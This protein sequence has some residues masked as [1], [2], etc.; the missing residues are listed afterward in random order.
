MQMAGKAVAPSLLAVG[1][2]ERGRLCL[3]TTPF[4]INLVC[5][6]DLS[7]ADTNND[8][9]VWS[10][11]MIDKDVETG[12]FCPLCS[13]FLSDVCGVHTVLKARS[14]LLDK[15]GHSCPFRFSRF[16]SSWHYIQLTPVDP[17]KNPKVTAAAVFIVTSVHHRTTQHDSAFLCSIAM[18]CLRRVI[19]R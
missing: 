11:P 3:H 6:S 13:A 9:I 15:D 19:I 14:G 18:V 4:F 2:I 10:F 5:S 7:C 12:V 8:L 16:G 17:A 1:V